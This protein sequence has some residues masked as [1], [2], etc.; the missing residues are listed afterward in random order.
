MANL[1]ATAIDFGGGAADG[2]VS[3]AG[4]TFTAS[5]DGY[6]LRIGPGLIVFRV[7]RLRRSGGEL[8][9]ELEV[10]CSV[11]GART[12]DDV[13]SLSIAN[14][15]LSSLRARTE[16]AKVLKDRSRLDADWEMLI[17]DL[18][19]R[20]LGAERAGAPAV[21]LRDVARPEAD[22]FVDVD[23]IRILTKHPLILFGDGG[24][25]KSLIALHVAGELARQGKRVLF[26]DWELDGGDHRDRLERLFGL[27]MPDVLYARCDRPLVHEADRLRRVVADE[28]VDYLVCDSVA[29]ACD[30]APESAEIAAN[31]FRAVRSCCVGSLHVAH[32]NKSEFGDQKPFGSAYWHNGARST[33]FV[34]KA[35][36]DAGTGVLTVGLYN[37]KA[38]MGPL[39][40]GVGLELS[41]D[42]ERTHVRRVDPAQVD[43]LAA[44]L[45]T[46]QKIRSLLRNG[47]L[48]MADLCSEV[49]GNSESVRKAVSRGTKWFTKLDDGRV[50]LVDFSAAGGRTRV[51]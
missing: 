3:Q 2:G 22:A 8:N 46:W 23:G 42:R 13:G 21:H 15:N 31:Y 28:G 11:P 27:E 48:T 37:R 44:K 29:F 34:Q 20:V 30:G 16:R 35:G 7:D 41:F 6:Q 39:R 5:A 12:T 38:N 47:P 50:A 4:R 24:T 43:D 49:G 14:F 32:V 9:G 33:W 26:A 25:G 10:R 19:Q 51:A 17:E 1:D 18:C 36:D 45:P 40:P